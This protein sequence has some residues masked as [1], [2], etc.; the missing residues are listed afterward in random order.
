MIALILLVGCFASVDLTASA[1][2]TV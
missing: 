2:V 1:P